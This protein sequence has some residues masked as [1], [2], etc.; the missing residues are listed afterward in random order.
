MSWTVAARRWGHLDDVYYDPATSQPVLS[1]KHGLLGRQVAL[2]PAVEAV[3][4]RD[5]VRV[6]YSA[7]QIER[8]QRGRVEDELSGEQIAAVGALFRVNL[9]SASL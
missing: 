7:E 3:L 4:S 2:I 9:P 6:P 1:V 8:A 5:Y